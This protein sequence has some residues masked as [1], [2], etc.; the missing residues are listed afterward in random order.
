MHITLRR[1]CRTAHGPP[2]RSTNNLPLKK[3]K[4]G[5]DLGYLLP[6]N[7]RVPHTPPYLTAPQRSIER[8]L[9][10]KSH[11]T[12]QYAASRTLSRGISQEPRTSLCNQRP[13]SDTVLVHV[14]HGP[15]YN[16][17]AKSGI[18]CH[19]VDILTERGEKRG[20]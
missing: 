20:G 19:Q 13:P 17:L 15:S 8:I 18:G 16:K 10:P 5:C 4:D 2:T 12:I 14:I 3:K 6:C 7:Q 11:P 1:S 9:Q